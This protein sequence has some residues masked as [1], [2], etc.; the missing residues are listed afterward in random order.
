TF[1]VFPRITTIEVLIA[2]LMPTF[3][4]F[5]W[6]AARPATARVGAV[7]VSFTPVQLALQSAYAANFVYFA[8]SSISL[9]LGVAL[10]A[11]ISGIV[12]FVGASWTTNRLLRSNRETLAAVAES[13]RRP[14]RVAVASLMQHRLALLAA[15]M[16]AIPDEA[17]S[18][19]V[20]LRQLR[21]AL[22]I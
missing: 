1:G 21:T 9:I 20:N 17:R 6:I 7:L 2:A 15:R 13:K 8:N 10:T 18:D 16:S 3:V 5:G 14:D 22:S 19:T 12:F 4:L 11:V